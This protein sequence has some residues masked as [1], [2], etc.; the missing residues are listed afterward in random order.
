MAADQQSFRSARRCARPRCASSADDADQQEIHRAIYRIKQS[1]DLRNE[2]PYIETL[3]D[4]Y[5]VNSFI[6]GC[7]EFHLLTRHLATAPGSKST[8]RCIDPLMSI[9][10]ELGKRSIA[11]AAAPGH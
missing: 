10:R 1:Q 11:L 6:A 7:T 3:L 4:K 5:R 2:I 8:Q 9:A